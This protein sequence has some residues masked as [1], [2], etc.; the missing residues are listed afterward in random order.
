MATIAKY[1]AERQTAVPLRA[2]V[3]AMAHDIA[4]QHGCRFLATAHFVERFDQRAPHP[5]RAIGDLEVAL[6]MID[7]RWAEFTG[8]KIAMKITQHVFIFDCTQPDFIRAVSF[9]ITDTPAPI[10]LAGRGDI[11]IGI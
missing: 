9:W 10:A 2:R 8:K 6:R 7:R 5:I 11:I 4:E 1:L 3:M